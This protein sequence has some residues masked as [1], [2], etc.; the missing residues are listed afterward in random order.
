[1]GKIFSIAFSLP[2][3]AFPFVFELA[4]GITAGALGF[5]RV[6]P[7]ANASRGASSGTTKNALISNLGDTEADIR[8]D[9]STA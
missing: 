6:T 8:D 2:F 5:K 9:D 3:F 7:G 1:L 4:P